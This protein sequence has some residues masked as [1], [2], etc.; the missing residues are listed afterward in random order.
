MRYLDLNMMKLSVKEGNSTIYYRFEG[1]ENTVPLNGKQL[2]YYV[3]VVGGGK[4]TEMLIWD[5]SNTLKKKDENGISITNLST[6]DIVENVDT[7]SM[8]LEKAKNIMNG[9]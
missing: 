8:T 2:Y 1:D 6:D 4:I 7:S 5:G 3:K 9:S